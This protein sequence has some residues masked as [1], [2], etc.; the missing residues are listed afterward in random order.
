MWLSRWEAEAR[1]GRS[2]DSPARTSPRRWSRDSPAR[3]SS[4]GR[5]RRGRSPQK[6][7]GVSHGRSNDGRGRRKPSSYE[8]YHGKIPQSVS[9]GPTF[10]P[11]LEATQNPSITRTSQGLRKR[12]K[13]SRKRSAEGPTPCVYSPC[14]FGALRLPLVVHRWMNQARMNRPPAHTQGRRGGWTKRM[15]W[16]SL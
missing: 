3:R 10:F 12:L 4:T 9:E 6:R 1:G 5:P 8:T 13:R 16:K 15:T 7:G 2:R 14:L 11:L